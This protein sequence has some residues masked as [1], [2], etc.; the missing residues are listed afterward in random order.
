MTT[1]RQEKST[2]PSPGNEVIILEQNPT[3]YLKHDLSIALRKEPE[4]A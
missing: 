4:N 1:T 3:P 2:K